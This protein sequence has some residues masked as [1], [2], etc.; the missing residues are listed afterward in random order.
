MSTKI[1]KASAQSRSKTI[2]VDKQHSLLRGTNL[3][4]AVLILL[5]MIV[6]FVPELGAADVMGSQ[7]FYL[8]ILDMLCL[9]YFATDKKASHSEA[10]Q[11]VSSSVLSLLYTGLFIL[12][13]LSIWSAIN[14]VESLVCYAR[15]AV[16]LIAYFNLA[17]LLYSRLNLFRLL[18]TVLSL[19]LLVQSIG[20]FSEFFKGY[21]D[22][23]LNVLIYNLKGNAGNKNILAAS[24]AIKLPFVLYN[25]YSSKLWGKL[26]NVLVLSL[27]CFA[28]AILNARASYISSLITLALY[29]L[30]CLVAIN[31]KGRAETGKNIALVVVPLVIAFIFSQVMIKNALDLQEKGSAYGT[32]GERL[33]T[34]SLT[35]EGSNY[36]LLQWNSAI[37]YIKKHPFI[38]A[39]YG[40]WKLAS[41]PYEKTFSNDLLVTYHVHNDFLEFAAETGVLGG[42]LLLAL[43]IVAV[44]Y[45]LNVLRLQ[46]GT[47]LS[48]ITSFSLIAL[49][50][51]FIDATFNFPMERPVMQ[52]F[53]VFILALLVNTHLQR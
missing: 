38:G 9:V 23:E 1:R 52:F 43:F 40:N 27:A 49:A 35:T 5:Y 39:G 36:R 28:I 32:L 17:I 44:I 29:L 51:Y 22:V 3:F 53:F 8:A 45:G 7:W 15:L 14:K 41:I 37:D 19:M 30:F 12:C 34:I 10:I 21:G 50:V 33:G 18:A 26:F 11:R 20:V 46:W 31:K 24:L 16:T 13:G 4:P 25:I 47:E 2:E 42:L 48:I 6:D